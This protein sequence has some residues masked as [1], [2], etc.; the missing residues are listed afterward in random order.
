MPYIQANRTR[1]Y[2][3]GEKTGRKFHPC[4]SITIPRRVVE[5]MGWK[6]GD[7]LE[8]KLEGGKVVLRRKEV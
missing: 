3:N 7:E 6:K 8:F 4:Y 5:F 1:A 2:R